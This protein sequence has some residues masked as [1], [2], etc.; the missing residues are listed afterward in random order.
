M[1]NSIGTAVAT[2][3]VIDGEGQQKIQLTSDWLY[4]FEDMAAVINEGATAVTVTGNLRILQYGRSAPDGN[5]LL[6][7]N[8]LT[9]S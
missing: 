7:P 3:A 4:E 5:I 2:Q 8:F 1:K 9:I 6:Q